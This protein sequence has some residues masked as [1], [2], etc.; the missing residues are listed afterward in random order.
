[1]YKKEN[2]VKKQLLSGKNIHPLWSQSGS[3]TIVEA[4][5]YA[6]W[7]VILI[8][9]EHGYTDLETTIHLIRAVEGAGGHVILRVPW[10]DHVYLKRILDIGVQTLMIPMI[11]DRKGAEDAV[12][13]CRYP[14]QGARG[15]AASVVRASGYGADPTYG[16]NA[17]DELLLI[18]QI[19]HVDTVENI[20]E[21]AAVDGIDM[22]FIGPMDLAG[23]MG[24]FENLQ[25][26]KVMAAVNEIE[27]RV[28]ASGKMLSG[29]P[30][31]GMSN[32]DLEQKGYRLVAGHCDIWLFRTAAAEVAGQLPEK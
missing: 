32:N 15:Y 28:L 14:P 2:W 27:K 30:L 7:P 18:A 6:G 3:A 5:V 11:N 8:D 22:L 12:A 21:I 29:Y 25:S 13:A 31:P 23:S 19:E 16:K 26:S 1:M 17:N 4:A 9:N 10:N 20:A 24:Q